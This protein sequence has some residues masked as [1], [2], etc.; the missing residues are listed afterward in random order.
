MRTMGVHSRVLLPGQKAFVPNRRFAVFG[1]NHFHHFHHGS[2]FFFNSCF[3]TFGSFGGFGCSNQFLGAG[4]W[5]WG[6]GIG[7][8]G[9]PFYSGYYGQPQQQQE[10]QPVVE[11]DSNNREIAFEMQA[12]RDEIQ[13]M[14]QEEHAREEARNTTPP[15]PAAQQDDDANTVL[16]FR[17]GRQLAV[18][19]YAV[20]DHT[21]WVLGPNNARKVQVSELDL[22]ATEQANAKNGVEFRLPR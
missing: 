5:G 15:R 2:R 3:N 17:D 8:P 21:I 16:V 7:Y 9:D 4:L 22:Q 1:F 6:P 13:V 10:Q 12:L 14:R 18:R 19:N 20:A 11:N